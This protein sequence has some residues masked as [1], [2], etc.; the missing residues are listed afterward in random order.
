MEKSKIK[1]TFSS[2]VSPASLPGAGLDNCC[3]KWQSFA[4]CSNVFGDA[5][6]QML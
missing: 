1:M 5:T 6:E 2:W 3:F 4:V